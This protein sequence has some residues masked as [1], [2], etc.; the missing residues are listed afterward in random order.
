M[1]CTADHIYNIMVIP[2]QSMLSLIY[3]ASASLLFVEVEASILSLFCL[4]W[5]M[6]YLTNSFEPCLRRIFVNRW[7]NITCSSNVSNLKVLNFASETYNM[8]S[9][10]SFC[11]N[12][13]SHVV[14]FEVTKDPIFLHIQYHGPDLKRSHRNNSHR[15]DHVM[16]VYSSLHK[17]HLCNDVYTQFKST[18]LR[19]NSFWIYSTTFSCLHHNTPITQLILLIYYAIAKMDP[20]LITG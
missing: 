6:L 10:P 19:S 14:E 9:H 5:A 20:G 8:Y 16:E 1:I 3:L 17:K 12:G 4:C 7:I 2:Q 13:M 15:N 11:S 18:S